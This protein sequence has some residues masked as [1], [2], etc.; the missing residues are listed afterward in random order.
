MVTAVMNF[1]L[2]EMG[3]GTRQEVV[4]SFMNSQ[5]AV[6]TEDVTICF[7]YCSPD[8]LTRNLQNIN[9]VANSM[10]IEFNQESLAVVIDGEMYFFAPNAAYK[11]RFEKYVAKVGRGK[12]EPFGYR[13][14]LAKELFVA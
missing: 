13:K 3:G 2:I 14:Y 12:A 7:A 4:G 5:E 10:A 9:Q 1:L 6:T 8:V 11:H